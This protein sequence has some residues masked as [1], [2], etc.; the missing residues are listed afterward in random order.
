MKNNE[1]STFWWDNSIFECCMVSIRDLKLPAEL[2]NNVQHHDQS[3]KC[4]SLVNIP[5]IIVC[6]VED[7]AEKAEIR[8]RDAAAERASLAPGEVL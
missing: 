8:P 4:S 2:V 3:C 1:F 7:C 6:H 5:E